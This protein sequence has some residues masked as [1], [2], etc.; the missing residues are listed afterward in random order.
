MEGTILDLRGM[1]SKAQRG[2]G[3]VGATGRSPLIKMKLR[4]LTWTV[5][6]AFFCLL[7]FPIDFSYSAAAF[8]VVT[9]GYP[10]PSGAM[11]PIWV[12]S[13]ARLDQKY[14]FNLQNI[15]ISGGARLTQSLVAGDLD[16]AG[17]GP[18]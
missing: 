11:L 13:Y 18:L 9:M 1:L 3:H 14:G 6:L 12:M 2:R 10:Q 4:V 7:L 8:P 16:I 17:N 5:F 15:Y